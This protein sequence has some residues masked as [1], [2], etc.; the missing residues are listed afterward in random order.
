VKRPVVV[1]VGLVLLLLLLPVVI[2]V[3]LVVVK[4]VG[5]RLVRSF[6]SVWWPEPPPHDDL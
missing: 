1:V 2:V 4:V 3:V 5:L 6:T